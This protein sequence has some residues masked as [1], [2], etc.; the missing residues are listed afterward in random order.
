MAGGG[1]LVQ[2]KSRSTLTNCRHAPAPEATGGPGSLSP[3]GARVPRRGPRDCELCP[4]QCEQAGGCL[5]TWLLLTQS[6]C[7]RMAG[8]GRYPGNSKGSGAPLPWRTGRTAFHK[9]TRNQDGRVRDGLVVP[10]VAAA[11]P[12]APSLRVPSRPQV[13]GD[14][15]WAEQSARDTRVQAQAPLWPLAASVSSALVLAPVG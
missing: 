13:D 15:A 9:G 1:H 3:Q 14:K 12:Q 2:A 11:A 5:E 6:P 8:R 4:R 7:G 10:S